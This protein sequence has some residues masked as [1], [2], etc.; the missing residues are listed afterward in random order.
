M[1]GHTFPT[2]TGQ[3]PVHSQPPVFFSFSFFLHCPQPSVPSASSFLT[4]TC[5]ASV[6]F[7]SFFF[8]QRPARP[9][10]NRPVPCNS[11][12]LLLLL[13]PASSSR[14]LSSLH[15]RS[16]HSFLPANQQP[17]SSSC[18]RPLLPPCKPAAIISL[19]P[20]ATSSSPSCSGRPLHLQQQP[21]THLLFSLATNQ[22]LPAQSCMAT[23]LLPGSAATAPPRCQWPLLHRRQQPL[24]LLPAIVAISLLQQPLLLFPAAAGHPSSPLY[25]AHPD[26]SPTP[27]LTCTSPCTSP[28]L[29][30]A[31]YFS[32]LNQPLHLFS[33]ETNTCLALPPLTTTCTAPVCNLFPPLTT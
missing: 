32:P 20:A 25:S 14:P 8:L 17:S 21:A 30:P 9:Y 2:T 5:T 18:P 23:P 19:L 24:L 15:C 1:T 6:S 12:P 33:P 13:P 10:T 27:L 31:Q 29:K 4:L 28:H 26:L 3:L 7:F 22:S 16:L 11:S